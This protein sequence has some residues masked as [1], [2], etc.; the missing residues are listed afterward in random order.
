MHEAV[1]PGVETIV[2]GF[3]GIGGGGQ[4]RCDEG[5][6]GGAFLWGSVAWV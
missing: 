4:G 2:V 6:D 3:G 1:L 5:S